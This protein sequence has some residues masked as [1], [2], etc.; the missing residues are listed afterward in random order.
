MG[1]LRTVVDTGGEGGTISALDSATVE[2]KYRNKYFKVNSIITDI[3]QVNSDMTD[4]VGP[5]K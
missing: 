3:L 4:P 5:G 2:I 1:R